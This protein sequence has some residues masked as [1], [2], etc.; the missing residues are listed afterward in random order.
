VIIVCDLDGVV[1]EWGRTARYMLKEY[2]GY[3]NLKDEA[4][5]W[6]YYE[7]MVSIEDWKWLWTEGIKLGLYRY[8]HVIKGAILGIRGL[9]DLGNSVVFVTHRPKSAVQ[10]TLDWLSYVRLQPAG[11]HILTNQEMKTSVPADLYIDDKPETISD[12]M[13]NSNAHAVVFNQPWNQVA[14]A[15]DTDPRFH[16]AKGWDDVVRI[17]KA[18]TDTERALSS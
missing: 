8:G 7:R 11:V 14:I 1:Y 6:D 13:L 2:K 3:N 12:V 16:R 15:G 9:Q 5:D 4:P 10:D 17:V 18:I